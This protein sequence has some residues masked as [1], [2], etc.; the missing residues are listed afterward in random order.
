MTTPS[1][2]CLKRPGRKPKRPMLH[3]SSPAEL[4]LWAV[5]CQTDGRKMA[6]AKRTLDRKS[7]TGLRHFSALRRAVPLHR[8][9]EVQ[10]EIYAMDRIVGPD[11]VFPNIAARPPIT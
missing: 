3:K 5:L 4:E 2:P 7:R 11:E 8:T 1:T 10:Q 9:H 6:A